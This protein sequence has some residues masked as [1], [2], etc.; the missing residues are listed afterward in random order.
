MHLSP[1]IPPTTP[2]RS[3]TISEETPLKKTFVVPTLRIERSLGDLTK[4]DDTTPVCGIS[5]CP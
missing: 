2:R 1:E 5:I 4:G 3:I